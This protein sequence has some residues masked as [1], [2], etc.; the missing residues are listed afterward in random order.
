MQSVAGNAVTLTAP[1]KYMHWGVA[2]EA[3]E[4][5]YKL[6][7]LLAHALHTHTRAHANARTYRA[8]LQYNS[9]VVELVNR[10]YSSISN[11]YVFSM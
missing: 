3:A 9:H 7:Y 6:E 11:L 5:G 4:V 8:L 2:P 10:I 1:L